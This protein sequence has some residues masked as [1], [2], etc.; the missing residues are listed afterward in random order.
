MNKPKISIKPLLA[1]VTILFFFLQSCNN[2]PT[3]VQEEGLFSF[4]ISDNG[5]K[6]VYSWVKDGCGSIYEANIDGSK[7]Q[8]LLESSNDMSFINPR[9]SWSGSKVVFIGSKRANV[10]SSVWEMNMDGSGLKRLT[11]TL[12]IRTEAIF[13]PA[14]D[15]VFFCQANDYESYSPIGRRAAHNYDIYSLALANGNIEKLTNLDSYGLFYISNLSNDQILFS[16]TDQNEGL[17]ILHRFKGDSIRKIIPK[18]KG[19]RD[20]LSYSSPVTIDSN[21]IACCS[22]YELLLIDLKENVETVISRSPGGQFRGIYFNK[23][24]GR[25]YF[26]TSAKKNSIFS[27]NMDGSDLV[28]IPLGII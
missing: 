20:F 4:A 6:I 17:F 11:D 28:E 7:P 12:R 10:T 26:N 5:N 15:T 27:I 3:I 2:E 22:Y 8:V 1:I 19:D 9:V 16:S 18:N 14:E 13:S 23:N 25:L 21:L 24:D